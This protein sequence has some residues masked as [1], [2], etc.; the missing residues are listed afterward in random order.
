MPQTEV[1]TSSREFDT[2]QTIT[3]EVEGL[4]ALVEF[5]HENENRDFSSIDLFASPRREDRA[6]DVW[7]DDVED[8]FA[9]SLGRVTT[10]MTRGEVAE[11]IQAIVKK[12]IITRR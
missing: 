2:F 7:H 4:F 1:K 8:L 9:I 10:W 6:V 12:A 3:T 5:F 11:M